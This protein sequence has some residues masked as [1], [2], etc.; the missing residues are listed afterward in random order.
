MLHKYYFIDFT[1]D[2]MQPLSSETSDRT[3]TKSFFGRYQ[4]TSKLPQYSEVLQ[5][6]TKSD[7]VYC[8]TVWWMTRQ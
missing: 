4:S 2:L 6:D 5:Q 8:I 3:S 7:K 1:H